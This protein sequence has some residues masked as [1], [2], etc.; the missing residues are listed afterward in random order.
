MSEAPEPTA[1]NRFLLTNLGIIII[2]ILTLLVLLAAYPT[3]LAPA[4]TL[5]PTI[6]LTP[7]VTP[8]FTQT[9]TITLTPTLTRTPR[10]TF[11]PTITPTPT[12]TPTPTQ[13]PTPTGPPTL[14]PALPEKGENIYSLQPWSPE[15]AAQMVDLMDYYPDTL[16]RQERGDNDENYY[17]AFRFA[18]SAQSEALL[19]YP[20]A[21]Q[22]KVWQWGL[23]YNLAQTGDPLAAGHYADLIA[24]GLNQGEVDPSGLSGWFHTQEPRMQLTVNQLS[25]ISGYLSSALIKVQG[26]GSAYLLLLETDNAFQIYPLTS[27][28]DFVN[29]PEIDFFGGDL[30]GDGKDEIVIYPSKPGTDLKLEPPHVF[31]LDQ[32]PP[33]ELPFNPITAP[34]KIGM[35]FSSNWSAEKDSNGEPLLR[36]ETTISP[37]C[38]AT[39][40]RTYRWA[41][42]WFDLDQSQYQ[43]QPNLGTLNFCQYVIDNAIQVWGPEAAIQVIKPIL[44]DWPPATTVNGKLYL[45]EAHDELSFRL[46]IQYALLGERTEAL[47]AFNQI[48]QRPTTV[49]SQWIQPARDF[50]AAYKTNEDI[51]RACVSTQYCDPRLAI[52]DLIDGLPRE[53]SPNALTYLWQHGVILR[54]SGYFDFDGDGTT[55]SWFTVRNHPGETLEFW[56]LVPYQTGIKA[57]F[58]SSIESN[59]PDISYYEPKQT[60]PVVLLDSSIAFSLKRIPE[61]L[62]PYLTFPELPKEYPNRFR[63]GLQAASD[64]LFSGEKPAS[65]QK[66]LLDLQDYPGLLC[67]PT[68]SCDP[69]YYLLG[70]SSEL[71]GDKNTAIDNYLYLWWNYSK[72]P[73]TTMARLKLRS[74]S[75]ESTATPTLTPTPTEATPTPTGSPGIP[76]ATPTTTPTLNPNASETPTPTETPS[77][78]YPYPNPSP[79]PTFTYNPYPTP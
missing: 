6:T 2:F 37:A 13:S 14:T 78:A 53:A 9:P 12:E 36:F 28:F 1:R 7:S 47:E 33:K 69:Y 49:T 34:L 16:P 66:M 58:I 19:R 79:P 77:T 11:T 35:D 29:N 5:T 41:G 48:I 74:I 4:P 75:V 25:S 44:P 42:K 68:W 15:R 64:A 30:T 72:S 62:Q 54:A 18:I 22:A 55:E 38:P 8:T 70:L 61:S 51:Y 27:G 26:R 46:G 43:V 73:Y 71:A 32:T 65:V 39:I 63:E 67:S 59:R 23:A 76:T 40:S 45:P 56:I 50:T 31:S 17:A 20:D 57:L 21:P 3:L 10:P 24:Q 52:M 60:P